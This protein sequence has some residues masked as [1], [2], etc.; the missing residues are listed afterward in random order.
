M[1]SEIWH[2][3]VRRDSPEKP[4]RTYGE[5]LSGRAREK[6]LARGCTGSAGGPPAADGDLPGAGTVSPTDG[7]HPTC[8]A[9]TEAGGPSAL[10]VGPQHRHRRQFTDPASSGRP[11]DGP[12]GFRISYQWTEIVHH[13]KMSMRAEKITMASGETERTTRLRAIAPRVLDAVP[14]RSL[15]KTGR[16]ST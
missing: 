11:L 12:L 6:S 2:S 3:F 14:T 10:P 1:C 4:C 5:V 8:V 15:P 9:A 7:R 13:H 16:L